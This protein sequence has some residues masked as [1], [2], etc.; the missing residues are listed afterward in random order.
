MVNFHRALIAS[1]GKKAKF[2]K[3]ESLRHAA[4]KLMK[5]PETSHPFYCRICVGG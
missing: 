5:K 4:L 1:P 2:T 3:S